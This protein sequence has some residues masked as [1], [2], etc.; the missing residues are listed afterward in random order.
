MRSLNLIF[1]VVIMGCDSYIDYA[2]LRMPVKNPVEYEFEASIEDVKKATKMAVGRIRRGYSIEFATDSVIVWGRDVLKEP[3]NVNDA[4]VYTYGLD[5]SRIYYSPDRGIFYYYDLH[6]H[7]TQTAKGTRVEVR[8]I[9]PR[10]RAGTRFPANLIPTP[11]RGFGIMRAVPPSTIEEYEILLAI[12]DALGV[13]HKMPPLILP[14]SPSK[15][16]D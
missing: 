6:L 10:I 1:L 2:E 13:K 3:A 9:D 11:I 16:G 12:G 8:T 7:L 14:E 15:G 5:S 4:F